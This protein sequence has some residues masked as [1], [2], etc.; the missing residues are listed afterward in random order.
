MSPGKEEDPEKRSFKFAFRT[1]SK[2][3]MRQPQHAT[4]NIHPQAIP[5]LPTHNNTVI[6]IF[7]LPTDLLLFLES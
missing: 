4:F 7:F 6:I 2:Q 3:K 1:F 5:K